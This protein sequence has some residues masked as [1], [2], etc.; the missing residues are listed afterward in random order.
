MYKSC[1]LLKSH[2]VFL[3]FFLV[4]LPL[5]FKPVLV[6]FNLLLFLN[7]PIYNCSLKFYITVERSNNQKRSMTFTICHT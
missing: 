1:V 6:C 3:E 2:A 7:I 5:I 4:L